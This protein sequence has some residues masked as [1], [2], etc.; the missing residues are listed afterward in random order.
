MTEQRNSYLWNVRFP[1]YI[2]TEED[3]TNIIE[4]NQLMPA[5]KALVDA[6][7]WTAEECIAYRI[8]LQANLHALENI[9]T[10]LDDYRT[11]MESRKKAESNIITPQSK[12]IIIPDGR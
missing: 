10:F 1:V 5:D 11:V 8:F 3:V 9:Q 12:K 7:Y 2:P 6:G 4:S